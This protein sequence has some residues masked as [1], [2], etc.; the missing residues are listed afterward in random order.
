MFRNCTQDGWSEIF[1]RPDL[2]CGVN[3]N[4]SSNE[5]RVSLSASEKIERSQPWVKIRG[6][7][8]ALVTHPTPLI[9]RGSLGPLGPH[10]PEMVNEDP[11]TG[12]VRTAL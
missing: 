11:G 6:P 5:K 3:V 12:T 7:G 4:D 9:I 1:P 10:S 2:A 8:A